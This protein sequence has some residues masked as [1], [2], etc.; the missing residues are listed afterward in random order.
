MPP[1]PYRQTVRRIVP[2]RDGWVSPWARALIDEEP[3]S[4]TEDAQELLEPLR[5]VTPG[6]SP[7]DELRARYAAK[8]A[9]SRAVARGRLGVAIAG[10]VVAHLPL[11]YAWF[12]WWVFAGAGAGALFA[13]EQM[14]W[15]LVGTT[16][17]ARDVDRA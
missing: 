4:G 9:Q 3:I 13:F 7:L 12:G 2:T 15:D 8:A 1:F 5:N 17:Q 14:R 6:K 10:V 11:P 16:L